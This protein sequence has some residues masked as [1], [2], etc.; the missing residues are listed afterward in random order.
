M[1][2]DYRRIKKIERQLLIYHFFRFSSYVE[3][4]TLKYWLKLEE[5][6][7]KTLQRDVKELNDSGLVS[8]SYNKKNDAY[9][10][11]GQ[12]DMVA[13]G[14]VR[15]VQHLTRLRRVG[16]LMDCLY[17][18]HVD[19]DEIYNQIYEKQEL[20]E[21]MDKEDFVDV[22]ELFSAKDCYKKLCPKESDRTMQRDFKLLTNIGYV[23]RYNPVMHYYEMEFPI[24]DEDIVRIKNIDGVLCIK[25]E[26]Y[27]K[28]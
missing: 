10:N 16:M 21:W 1:A 13:D 28:Y 7:R 4:V 18:D 2:G 11:E 5:R 20:L 9:I 22:R 23:V 14:E 26:D 27:E 19:R 6:H 15:Y 3:V 24:V 25:E 17:Q 8:L 12:E